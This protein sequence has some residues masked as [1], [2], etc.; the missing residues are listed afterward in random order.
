MGNSNCR[1]AHMSLPLAYLLELRM[2]TQLQEIQESR[3]SGEDFITADGGFSSERGRYLL[4]GA[5]FCGNHSE[6][7]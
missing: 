6:N 7:K 3:L 2:K 1:R 4:L 5:N